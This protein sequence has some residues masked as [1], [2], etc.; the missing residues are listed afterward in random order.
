MT[1]QNGLDI[2]AV[3]ALDQLNY[4]VKNN[5]EATTLKYLKMLQM[6]YLVQHCNFKPYIPIFTFLIL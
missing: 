4:T 1:C 3:E 6:Q 5:R 2:T